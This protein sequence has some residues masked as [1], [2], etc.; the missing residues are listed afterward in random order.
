[1]EKLEALEAL[2]DRGDVA[3]WSGSPESVE[4]ELDGSTRMVRFVYGD[5]SAAMLSSGLDM[6]REAF[7]AM[8]RVSGFL[9]ALDIDAPK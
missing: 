8:N 5:G 7:D 6:P 1:M 3:A 9:N 4:D 2:L